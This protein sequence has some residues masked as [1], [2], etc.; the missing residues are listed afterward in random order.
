MVPY[1]WFICDAFRKVSKLSPDS[2]IQMVFV[3]QFRLFR[4][5][6]VSVYLKTTKICLKMASR[7]DLRQIR[8]LYVY[9]LQHLDRQIV[10]LGGFSQIQPVKSHWSQYKAF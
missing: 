7:Y 8:D 3:M 10:R 9:E 5:K 1:F 6:R 4:K 2:A